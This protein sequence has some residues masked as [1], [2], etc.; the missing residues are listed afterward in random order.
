MSIINFIYK[1]S[2]INILCNFNDRK[3]DVKKKFS[4]KMKFNS[5]DSYLFLYNGNNL[6]E[7]LTIEEIANN[8]DKQT[9]KMNILVI[10]IPFPNE[11][12]I[13]Y[14]NETIEF[15]C[16]PKES[17]Y[18]I[19]KKFASSKSKDISSFSFF[20]KGKIMYDF[21]KVE[22]YLDKKSNEIEICA[23]DKNYLVKSKHIICPMCGEST[24]LKFKTFKIALFECKN[25]HIIDNLTSKEFE[26]SQLINLSYIACYTGKNNIGNTYKNQF[27]YCIDCKLNFCPLCYCNHSKIHKII[28]YD[29]KPYV[30]DKH[31]ERYNSFCKSC[32]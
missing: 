10:E 24:R 26:T 22:T 32:L 3:E 11:V 5:L 15:K 27:Y 2:P 16:E 20:H 9:R 21:M 25:N 1:G 12:K 31:S 4:N 6:N 14:N 29:F 17:I 13:K 28:Y 18:N 7:N 23:I 30:C 8:E 19:F